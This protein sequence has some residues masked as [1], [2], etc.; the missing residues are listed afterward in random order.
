M[1]K[2]ILFQEKN[3]NTY[4]TRT[5][6]RQHKTLHSQS[7]MATMARPQ[8]TAITIEGHRCSR[9]S[10]DGSTKCTQHTKGPL[11]SGKSSATLQEAS[12]HPLEEA[13]MDGSHN[14]DTMVDDLLDEVAGSSGLSGLSNESQVDAAL[15]SLQ[16]DLKKVQTE[17][18]V[19]VARE[20]TLKAKIAALTDTNKIA[21]KAKSLF[22]H[23]TKEDASIV[24]QLQPVLNKA[25][26]LIVRKGKTII[27]WIY[28][29]EVTDRRFG[30]LPA[31][32]HQSW[33]DKAKEVMAG[34]SA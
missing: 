25:G 34:C 17:K 18:A 15:S 3:N 6:V 22:Y 9:A 14:V 12:K 11:Q 24:S 20:R 30:D 16:A 13:G 4:T 21:K 33:M 19:L 29:R 7:T 27:P 31:S 5:Q 32:D 1:Q 8:C 23:A 26:L 28:I 10:A 2:L